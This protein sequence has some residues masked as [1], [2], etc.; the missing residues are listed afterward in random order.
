M[1]CKRKLKN[2]EKPSINGWFRGTHI[3][4]RAILGNLHLDSHYIEVFFPRINMIRQVMFLGETHQRYFPIFRVFCHVGF[5]SQPDLEPLP[6]G[7]GVIQTSSFRR[8]AGPPGFVQCENHQEWK[9]EEGTW[10]VHQ[11]VRTLLDLLFL[12]KFLEFDSRKNSCWSIRKKSSFFF[13]DFWGGCW[14][15]QP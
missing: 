6:Q 1:I 2:H 15:Q 4:G 8:P 14:N 12:V 7:C 3:L 11:T 10:S 13:A 9:K 5:G